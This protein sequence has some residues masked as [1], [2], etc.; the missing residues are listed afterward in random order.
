MKY[1]SKF[2][3]SIL[4]V[5]TA[6]ATDPGT[7]PHPGSG[8]GS[9]SGSGGA[10]VTERLC[11]RANTCNSLSG[12]VDECIQKIDAVLNLLPKNLRAEYDLAIEGC[13]AHP[14]CDGYQECIDTIFE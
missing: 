7:G 12:S 6:C 13:L 11:N 10:N 1:G 14:S 5:L 8:S 9:G 3:A 4:F 2:F